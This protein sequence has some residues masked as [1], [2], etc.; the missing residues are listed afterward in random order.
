MKKQK[1]CLVS[2]FIIYADTETSSYAVCLSHTQQDFLNN[3]W[4]YEAR[5]L[6]L[7]RAKADGQMSW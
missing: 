2:A 6:L 5:S 1:E 3:H 4:K 7:D